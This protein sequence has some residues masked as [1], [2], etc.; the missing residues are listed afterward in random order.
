MLLQHRRGS[1]SSG[2]SRRLGGTFGSALAI[3]FFAALIA[4][5]Y[6]PLADAETGD[7]CANTEIRAQQGSE[8]LPDCMA[9]EL[10]TPPGGHAHVNIDRATWSP[11]TPDGNTVCF[12][13]PFPMAGATPIGGV[14]LA[15]GYCGHRSDGGWD[16]EWI[17]RPRGNPPAFTSHPGPVMYEVSE[18]GKRVA[19]VSTQPIYF[20]PTLFS[21]WEA[22]DGYVT[23]RGRDMPFWV[24]SPRQVYEDPVDVVRR[25]IYAASADLSHVLYFRDYESGG[26][27][28]NPPG[29]SVEG[30]R[31]LEW[32]DGEVRDV[33]I[34]ANGEVQPVA[35][36]KGG[37]A[38]HATYIT[39]TVP[40]TI[41]DNGSRVFFTAWSGLAGDPAYGALSVYI[42]ENG[43]TT[44]LLTPRREDVAVRQHIV[45]VGGTPDGKRAFVLTREQLTDE[46]LATPSNT[47]LGL[48]RIDVD[49]NEIELVQDAVTR[50]LG[51][52]RDGS[53]IFLLGTDM[54]GPGEGRSLYAHRNGETE[55]VM[56][57]TDNDLNGGGAGSPARVAAADQTGRALRIS[58]D[59]E[60]AAFVAEGAT[61]GS[62][63]LY[64]W[65]PEGGAEMIGLDK[66][67]D[68]AEVDLAGSDKALQPFDGAAHFANKP[69]GRGIS[70]D[71]SRIYLTTDAQMVEEDVNEVL[72][73]Y[74]WTEEDGMQ[75]I[76]TGH[77]DAEDSVYLDNSEDGKTVFFGS[78]E[79]ILPELDTNSARD[80][81]AAR[82]GGGFKHEPTKPCMGE[83][84]QGKPADPPAAPKTSTV[85]FRGKGNVKP[86]TGKPALHVKQRLRIRGAAGQLRL[87]VPQR[88]RVVVN[89]R[90][91][92]RA[93]R[94]VRRAGAVGLRLTLKP[95]FRKALNRRGR[96]TTR[97]R[98]SYRAG[99]GRSTA[100]AVRVAFV[101]R[102]AKGSAQGRKK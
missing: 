45:F 56:P 31:L 67:G 11:A 77:S 62:P 30:G 49:T 28:S 47:R 93:A 29:D 34:D 38:G 70:S 2:D 43:E 89:G 12:S 82:A 16:V 94:V 48:Y 54:L 46:P 101:K 7:E 76:S 84:C 3:V 40:G 97:V 81:Y 60:V 22:S 25:R 44:R 78:F 64:R 69:Q 26:I 10:V 1:T 51:F 98:I 14:Q 42:R 21:T 92:R 32:V 27:P 96:V 9:Y 73:V 59:G 17:T 53:T 52:S 5:I 85:D 6:A 33:G 91:V 102:A 13:S 74:V 50:L 19:W 68:K 20:A 58:N 83:E 15:D 36:S 72:D 90:G 37:T 57:L 87:R 99:D 75:L 71:G 8:H 35:L 41:S 65:T 24:T 100:R 63:G 66:N 79:R 39:R 18:D 80:V 4:A 61:T 95:R 88:G 86:G 55:R 23:E